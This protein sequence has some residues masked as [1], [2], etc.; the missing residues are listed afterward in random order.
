[1]TFSGMNKNKGSVFAQ[2]KILVILMI[3]LTG[4]LFPLFISNSG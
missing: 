4:Y 1:M 2:Q 3:I